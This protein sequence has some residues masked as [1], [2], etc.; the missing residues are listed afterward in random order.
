MKDCLDAHRW[1]ERMERVFVHLQVP[2]E[3]W[4]LRV[5]YSE[6]LSGRSSLD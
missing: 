3:A 2:E 1:I 4:R 5:F 6:G